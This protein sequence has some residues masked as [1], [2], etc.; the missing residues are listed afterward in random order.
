MTPELQATYTV[1]ASAFP[2]NGTWKLR[3]TDGTPGFYSI[4]DGQIV[5]W[6]IAF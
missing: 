5:S 4:P 1:D 2:A 6:S 3:V